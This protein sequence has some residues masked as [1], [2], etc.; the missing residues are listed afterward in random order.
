MR[1]KI[2]GIGVLACLFLAGCGVYSFTGASVSPDTR[3]IT[4]PT[5]ADRS[6]N[7]PPYL[8][9]TFSEKTREYFLRNTSLSLSPAEGD[10]KLEA[11]ITQYNLSPVAPSGTGNGLERAAQT[12]LTIGV[13]VKFTNSRNKEQ[14]FD[15]V[16]SFFQDFA[17]TQSFSGVEKEL[18]ETISDQ[19]IL[20]IFNKS[21]A[22]W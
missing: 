11:T 3:T 16:F 15:Q 21:V 6:A 13:R 12:R 22:N 7:S 9:Q 10:L 14:N 5:F 18:T 8:A 17:Q 20:D 4:I 1:N 19:I 2:F